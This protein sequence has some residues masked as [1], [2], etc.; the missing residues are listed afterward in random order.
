MAHP[1]LLQKGTNMKVKALIAARSGSVRVVNKNLRA[2]VG[3]SLL[4]LKI[5][6]LKRIPNIDGIVVNSN[7]DKIL[8][9]AK[10]EG[11]G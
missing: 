7:D 9:I 8:S 6:Q 10:A 3:S 4:E 2:F 11:G 5:E 1:E